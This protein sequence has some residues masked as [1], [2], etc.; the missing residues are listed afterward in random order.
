MLFSLAPAAP[1]RAPAPPRNLPP[2]PQR[3][4]I[5][6]GHPRCAVAPVSDFF[7]G[8]EKT[9]DELRHW[10]V[11]RSISP[12]HTS[13]S[14][15]LIDRTKLSRPGSFGALTTHAKKFLCDTRKN[16]SCANSGSR[17]FADEVIQPAH[18]NWDFL[19]PSESA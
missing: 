15:R 18:I 8:Q 12:R 6:A 9:R 7:G 4:H 5:P 14:A 19:V 11:P 2:H 17:V 13:G 3:R 16:T 1:V 10:R